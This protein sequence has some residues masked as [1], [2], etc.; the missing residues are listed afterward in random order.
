MKSLTQYISE[1]LIDDYKSES[2]TDE[3][4][5]IMA[6]IGELE[7]IDGWPRM[8]VGAHGGQNDFWG[9]QL[10]ADNDDI[11]RYVY[12]AVK[13]SSKRYYL[14]FNDEWLKD[15]AL[16]IS[17]M[18]KFGFKS[19]KQQ[20][21]FK[22]G[23][24]KWYYMELCDF[25]DDIDEIKDVYNELLDK[26]YPSDIT[27]AYKKIARMITDISTSGMIETGYLSEYKRDANMSIEYFYNEN[28]KFDLSKAVEKM[29]KNAIKDPSKPV[30]VHFKFRNNVN[31]SIITSFTE[32]GFIKN[33]NTNELSI[34]IDYLLNTI[35]DILGIL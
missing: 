4:N 26:L 31:K 19:D 28:N 23:D 6:F 13:D 27:E 33:S 24:G 16:S 8:C 32:H 7:D 30:A 18:K 3:I 5:N 34:N 11:E 9:E 1:G 14:Y 17:D 2:R 15:G 29:L 10:K 20:P 35:D 22:G 12:K 25:I 21:E